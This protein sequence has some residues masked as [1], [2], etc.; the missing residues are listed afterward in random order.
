MWSWSNRQEA[1]RPVGNTSH[2]RYAPPAES[3]AI[4]YIHEVEQEA[5]VSAGFCQNGIIPLKR[6]VS[7]L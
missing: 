5:S 1:Q 6:A 2:R 3:Q 4:N 7:T